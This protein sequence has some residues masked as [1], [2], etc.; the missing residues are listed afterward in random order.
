[1]NI[2]E[3][4]SIK[5]DEKASKKASE[6]TKK[7][8]QKYSIL[9][10]LISIFENKDNVFRDY[11]F[12]NYYELHL[13]VSEEALAEFDR[14]FKTLHIF[15]LCINGVLFYKNSRFNT[16]VINYSDNIEKNFRRAFKLI[17][18]GLR[19]QAEECFN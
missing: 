8:A 12:Y 6:I 14:C 3:I 4:I 7:N 5:E 19:D 10:S 18:D 2:S 1:M 16:I 9:N 15:E 17:L 13:Y 11:E